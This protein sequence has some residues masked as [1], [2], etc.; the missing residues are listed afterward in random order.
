MQER[1]RVKL[2]DYD[3]LESVS[4][5]AVLD[6]LKEKGITLR[7]DAFLDLVQMRRAATVIRE[8]MASKG[9]PYAEVTPSV[10]A[11]PNQPQLA[12]HPL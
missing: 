2:V 6:A 11:L 12:P 3:G 1:Q 4:Q 7:L 9:F 5:S 10:A 8:L